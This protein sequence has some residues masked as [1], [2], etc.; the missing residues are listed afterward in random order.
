MYTSIEREREREREREGG[1]KG[2]RGGR[3]GEIEENR[4]WKGRRRIGRR[5]ILLGPR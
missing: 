5:R 3:G 1:A 2:E 4:S